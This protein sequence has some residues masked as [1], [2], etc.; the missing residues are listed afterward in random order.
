MSEKMVKP[1]DEHVRL[2]IG[3]IFLEKERYA[4][5]LRKRAEAAKKAGRRGDGDAEPETDSA[6][7]ADTQ[8][9][10]AAG[11]VLYP[12]ISFRCMVDV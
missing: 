10:Q 11:T 2:R 12:C 9:V 6:P 3:R 8:V 1:V 4:Y 5:E 7:R